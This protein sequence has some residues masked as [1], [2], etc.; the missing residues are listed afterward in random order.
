MRR[1][2]HISPLF[3]GISLALLFFGPDAAARVTSLAPTSWT[4]PTPAE[5][6]RL[7]TA[8]GDPLRFSLAALAQD[9]PGATITIGAAGVPPGATFR[10]IPGNPAAAGFTW[11]PRPAQAGRTYSLTFTAQPDDQ[12]VPSRTR[13]VDVHVVASKSTRFALSSGATATY[14]WAFVIRRV[15]ARSA[16]SRSA[17]P[18]TRLRL[19]TPEK[20]T[21]LVQAIE[22]RRTASGVWVRVRLSILPNNSTGWVPRRTLGNWR[23]VRTHLLVDRRRLTL[24]LYRTGKPVFWARVGVGQ[25]QSPTPAGQFY[26]RNML[27]GFDAPVYGPVAFGTSARSPVLTD[28]PGGGFIGIHGTDEPRLLPGRVSHGCVRLRNDDMLR[29]ARL[30]PVGTPMTVR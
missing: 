24:T 23:T 11:V 15:I 1:S 28:W 21:N 20:T 2:R 10:T 30:L 9:A 25:P 27:Y 26:V 7:Q 16:P 22:G 13:R 29:L 17:A 14:R 19:L 12:A 5:G 18:V 3:C 8:P 4:P 6:T